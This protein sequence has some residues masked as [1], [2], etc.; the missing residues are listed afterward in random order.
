MHGSTK[1]FLFL[2]VLIDMF[3]K[4]FTSKTKCKMLIK[5]VKSS[6]SLLDKLGKHF[7]FKY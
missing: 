4:N 2:L 1:L 5:N 3:F 7:E 6:W